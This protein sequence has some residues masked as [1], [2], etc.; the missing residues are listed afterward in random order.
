MFHNI[1]KQGLQLVSMVPMRQ[2]FLTIDSD[3]RELK[4]TKFAFDHRKLTR[5]TDGFLLKTMKRFV[6]KGIKKICLF[7]PTLPTEVKTP[8]DSIKYILVA[9]YKH[10]SPQQV[11]GNNLGFT[12]ES[13]AQSCLYTLEIYK[14]PK[15]NGQY[16]DFTSSY[17][18][19]NLSAQ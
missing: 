4:I 12:A 9:T 8:E 3:K 11:A 15:A 16:K 5:L 10:M 2:G 7:S 17:T 1:G 6:G 19:T 14:M 18:D 13:K